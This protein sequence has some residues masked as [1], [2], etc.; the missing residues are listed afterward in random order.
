MTTRG[1]ELAESLHSETSEQPTAARVETGLQR[2]LQYQSQ[3]GPAAVV[4]K[5]ADDRSTLD[6]SSRRSS[7]GHHHSRLLFDRG[8]Q[9]DLHLEK[10]DTVLVV[11]REVADFLCSRAS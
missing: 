7:A 4:T 2:C 6:G 10:D 11:L 8:S 5:A 9:T 3:R 1:S